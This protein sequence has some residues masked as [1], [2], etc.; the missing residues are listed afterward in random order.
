M[1]KLSIVL[2]AYNETETI[3]EIVSQ[4][5]AVDLS[6]LGV[7]TELVIVDDCSKDGTRDILREM[8]AAN[9]ATVVYHETNQ[10][11]G[12]AIRSGLA[13][14]TGDIIIIQDADL[15][16]DPNDYGSLVEPIVN[17]GA[18]VVYGSRQLGMK[19]FGVKRNSYL[20]FYLGGR[21][22]SFLTN[23]LYGT[24]ITDEATCYKVFTTDVLKKIPPL[25]C[26]GFEFCPELT[27]KV[28]LA[29]YDI[30]EIPIHYYPRS[31]EEGK[32]I[33]WRDGVIA[34]QTLL[35]YRLKGS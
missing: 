2:P 30:L 24:R 5:R 20:S 13:H 16:Y 1:H 33:N 12:A 28:A 6:A 19:A 25:V 23:V 8:E 27:A 31:K 11:K 26:T 4:V 29:G 17:G 14:V 7:E 9:E 18:D 3:R 35:K 34:I 10:G 22:L 15:E 32:K 21:F